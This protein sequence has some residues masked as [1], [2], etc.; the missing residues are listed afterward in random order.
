ME[1]LRRQRQT[2]TLTPHV[3]F[4]L[5]R[6]LTPRQRQGCEA[7]SIERLGELFGLLPFEKTVAK[8]AAHMFQ[9]LKR[10][11]IHVPDMDLLIAASAIA[12]G[13]H[14]IVT[15]DVAHFEHFKRFGLRVLSN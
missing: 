13:D 5:Y 1:T 3:L 9:V 14:E 6:G 8:A 4:E 10:D 7:R 12:W 11:G 2:P 15:A